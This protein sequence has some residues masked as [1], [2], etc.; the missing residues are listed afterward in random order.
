[1][2]AGAAYLSKHLPEIGSPRNPKRDTYY[3]YYATLSL[4]HV[5]GEHWEAWNTYLQ[6]TVLPLQRQDGHAKGSWDPDP[7]WI[8]AAGGRVSTTAMGVLMSI[9]ARLCC[10]ITSP[11][12]RE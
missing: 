10:A 12:R 1:M 6:R 9:M 5:G 11:V 3:W 4:F 2:Q 8:G 7:N